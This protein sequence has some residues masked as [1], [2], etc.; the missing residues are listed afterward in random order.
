MQ[1]S[2]RAIIFICRTFFAQAFASRLFCFWTALTNIYGKAAELVKRVDEIAT[3]HFTDKNGEEKTLVRPFFVEEDVGKEAFDAVKELGVL[4]EK[5][6]EENRLELFT[7]YCRPSSLTRPPEILWLFAST[8][9]DI[10]FI[11]SLKASS[12]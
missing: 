9:D 10:S 5:Y 8:L 1:F 3:V 11:V 7:R 4:A 6:K 2:D 12:L